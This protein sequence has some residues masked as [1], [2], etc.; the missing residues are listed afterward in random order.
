M[1]PTPGLSLF[2]EGKCLGK[3]PLLKYRRPREYVFAYV[4]Q[5]AQG[6]LLHEDFFKTSNDD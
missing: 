2:N 1:P 3:S 5:S 6:F 4:P